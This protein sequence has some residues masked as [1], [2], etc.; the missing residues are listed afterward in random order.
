M[1]F[2]PQMGF[3][4]NCVGGM[5]VFEYDDKKLSF[6]WL[7]FLFPLDFIDDDCLTEHA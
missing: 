1:T 3:L 6:L 2:W 5:E 4:K 7:L